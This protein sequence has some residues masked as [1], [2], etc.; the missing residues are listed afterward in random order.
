VLGVAFVLAA[1]LPW[2]PAAAPPLLISAGYLAA[3]AM[4]AVN[5]RPWLLLVSAG[6]ALNAAAIIAN[7]GRMPVSPRALASAGR[8]VSRALIAGADP[9]HLVETPATVLRALDDHVAFHIGSLAGIV[10]PGDLLMA[11]G[12]AGFVQAGMNAPSPDAPQDL[13]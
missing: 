13:R 8:P 5:R 10:S 6:A 7:G 4:L 11:I 3:L 12:V 9:R 2:L 1:Q